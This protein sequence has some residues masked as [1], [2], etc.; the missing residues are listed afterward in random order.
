MNTTQTRW[1]FRP[2]H[3]NWGDYGPDD[4]LGQLNEIT[5]ER[6]RRAFEEATDGIAFCLSLP[7][8][9]G[10]RLNASR[11]PPSLAAALRDGRPRY[12][13]CARDLYAGLTDV[14][15]DDR[16]TLYTQFSTQWDALAHVGALFDADGD[17][18]PEIRYYN[19]WPP[20][21]IGLSA[22]GIEH[23]AATGV[24]GRGV[25]INL[26]R[27]FGATRV[28]VGYEKLARILEIDG[29]VV[30]PGDMVCLHTGF[31]Q[32]LLDGVPRTAEDLAQACPVLDG[33]DRQLHEWISATRIAVL[34]ADNVAIESRPAAPEAG[35]TGPLLP[36]HEHCLFKRG[37]HLGELWHLTPL[38]R[39]LHAHQRYRFLLTAPPLRLPG[40][41]GSPA[42]PVA[43][44]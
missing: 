23:M 26:H 34:A 29:I 38:A 33:S 12:N 6:R 14:V 20:A 25:L 15:C 37:V 40:A 2:D 19:G 30:E 8:D 13:Q 17:G 9:K 7:L 41:A 11:H 36:L 5:P 39:W 3:S 10:P 16:V 21:D 35:Y 18:E 32:L 1:R 43:T 24:Q 42:T 44:V 4:R 28:Q 27:H 31:A 22:L